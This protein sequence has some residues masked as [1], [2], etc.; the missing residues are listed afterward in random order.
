M[1]NTIVPTGVTEDARRPDIVPELA[2]I[3]VEEEGSIWATTEETEG[4]PFT[5]DDRASNRL[6]YVPD[7]FI[8]IT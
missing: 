4:V 1:I 8:A 5:I 7:E 6:A 3:I 2:V